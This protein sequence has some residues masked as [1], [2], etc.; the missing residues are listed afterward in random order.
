[1]ARSGRH[2][3]DVSPQ[4]LTQW[5]LP[6]GHAPSTA[7]EAV[8]TRVRRALKHTRKGPHCLGVLN[9]TLRGPP[10][11]GG[12]PSTVPRGVPTHGPSTGH[13]GVPSVVRGLNCPHG[14]S[15]RGPCALNHA[16]SGSPHHKAVR[17]QLPPRGPRTCG[18]QP[19]KASLASCCSIWE[20]EAQQPSPRQP[21]SQG[22]TGP[23]QSSHGP[24]PQGP[25]GQ[26][27]SHT[28]VCT[29]W[30]C[31]SLSLWEEPHLSRGHRSCLPPTPSQSHER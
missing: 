31:G 28:C 23:T 24:P 17:P 14:L 16:R 11:A 10:A 21:C 12:A 15:T 20:T 1:M 22:V 13:E 5:F 7:H 6:A 27:S 9:H 30:A 25:K 29:G 26:P 3:K 19:Q 4:S 18:L 8:P 2:H